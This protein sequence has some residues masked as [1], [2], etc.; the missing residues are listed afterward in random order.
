MMLDED[1][2]L[3]VN[4]QML[5]CLPLVD[6]HRRPWG[7]MVECPKGELQSQDKHVVLTVTSLSGSPFPI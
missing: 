4:D 7:T 3:V 5:C 2:Y 1:S 6:G